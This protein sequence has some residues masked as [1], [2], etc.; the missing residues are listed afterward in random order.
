MGRPARSLGEGA[1]PI[2]AWP[3]SLLRRHRVTGWGEIVAGGAF[4]GCDGWPVQQSEECEPAKEGGQQPPHHGRG[5]GRFGE[6]ESA[7]A[8]V[9]V[10]RAC[11]YVAWG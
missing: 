5:Q 4:T 9:C 11:V 10:S 6:H 1:P 7:R 8:R 2:S 3:A